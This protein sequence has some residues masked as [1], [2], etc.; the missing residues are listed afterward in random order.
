MINRSS[1]L[2]LLAGAIPVLCLAAE[3]DQGNTPQSYYSAEMFTDVSGSSTLIFDVNAA[4]AS[5]N[6]LQ[7][8]IGRSETPNAGLGLG[9]MLSAGYSTDPEQS[10]SYGVSSEYWRL[11]GASGN[12]VEILSL[13]GSATRHSD[14][15]SL[16]ATPAVKKINIHKQTFPPAETEVTS[17]GVTLSAT[18]YTRGKWSFSTGIEENRYFGDAAALQTI[19]NIIKFTGKAPFLASLVRSRY[20]FEADYGFPNTTLTLGLDMNKTVIQPKHKPSVYVRTVSGLSD[21]WSLQTQLGTNSFDLKGW[22]VSLGL[23]YAR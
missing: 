11:L 13:S 8:G 7:F 21:T 3:P 20:Y 6:R 1:I 15:W 2:L 4:L 17:G 14:R 12:N 19:I 9:Y 18:Y 10:S 5:R 23:T 16:V 22:F